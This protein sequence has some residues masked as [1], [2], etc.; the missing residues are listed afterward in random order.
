MPV[1]ILM[2]FLETKPTTAV[3]P[4]W[5]T[6]DT[7]NKDEI[8][9]VLARLIAKAVAQDEAKADKEVGDE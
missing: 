9:R 2:R 3:D 7:A 4:V 6:L 1:Q 8:A 5:P